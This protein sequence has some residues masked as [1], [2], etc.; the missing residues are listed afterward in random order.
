MLLKGNKTPLHTFHARRTR[1]PHA[2][3]RDSH[4]RGATIVCMAKKEEKGSEIE[5][6][7]HQGCTNPWETPRGVPWV[8]DIPRGVPWVW[9]SLLK[10]F[11]VHD[12]MLL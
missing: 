5:Q 8:W 3:E 11:A 10:N 2:Q 7:P 9:A 12:I 6:L 1:T 4:A